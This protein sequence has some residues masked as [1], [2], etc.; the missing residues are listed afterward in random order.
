MTPPGLLS[1]LGISVPPDRLPSFGSCL[2]LFYLF[3]L[4]VLLFLFVRVVRLSLGELKGLIPW[5]KDS[6]WLGEY[7]GLPRWGRT[8]PV[9]EGSPPGGSMIISPG[10]ERLHPPVES[11]YDD[12]PWWGTTSPV[13]SMM[14]S[15][16]WERLPQ[17]GV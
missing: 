13:G 17:W 3:I 6:P 10:G 7:D 1:N 16:G 2:V 11:E 12:L 15:P 8:P 9:G 4:V 14:I 5:G